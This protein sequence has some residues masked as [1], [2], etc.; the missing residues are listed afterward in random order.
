MINSVPNH[1][2]V[3]ARTGFLTAL[4]AAPKQDWMKVAEKFSMDAKTQKLVDLG[5]APMPTQNKGRTQVQSFIEKT[6]DITPIDWDITVGISYNDVQDDQ[7][8]NLERRV[9]SAGDNFQKHINKHVFEVLNAGDGQTYGAC[10]DGQDFFDSDHVD[11]G[12]SYTTAQDN[13]GA[14]ALSLDNFETTRVAA[15]GFRDD[16]GEFT[17]YNYNLLVVPPALENLAAQI[18][19]NP[20]AYDIANREINPY[21]GST[22]MIVSPYLDSTAWFLIAANEA[23]KPL[24][25]AMREEPN[26]QSSWF[27]PNAGNGGMY[28]FKFYARYAVHYGDWRLAYMGNS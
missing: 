17:D 9:R 18:C 13:E 16:Q 10:Y 3:G 4:E 25:L 5:A 12:A 8:G 23:V 7:T 14:L 19:L 6:K 11:K 2:V 24:I 15:M 26:L 21:A 1:L 22:N 27:D 28:Y 20:Q